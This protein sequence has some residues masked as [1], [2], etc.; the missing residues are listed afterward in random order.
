M[1]N[2]PINLWDAQLIQEFN[3]YL[4][5]IESQEENSPKI[6]VIS[7]DVPDF[8]IA[9]I[10]L[11]LLSVAHPASPTIN[12]TDILDKYYEN[13]NL[14]SRIPVVFIAEINGRAWGAG[15]EHSMHMDI[16]FAG[17]EALFSA[18]EASVGLIHVGAMQW[19]V[20]SL[21]P[22]R[23][24]EYMLGSLQVDATEAVRVGWV[25]SAY[26]TADGLRDHVDQLV[27]RIARFDIN[28]IKATKR[29][30]AQQMPSKAIFDKDQAAF[31][32]LAADPDVQKVVDRVLELSGD[33]G[34]V[35]E[36]NNSDN[37]VEYV[38]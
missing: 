38:L 18:P 26:S 12:T 34:K 9:A 22:S 36:L 13:L 6:V 20:K 4:R 33:Q 3:T 30:I 16:R 35:W 21:G 10:D 15:D 37:I 31:G 2:P 23:T 29:S 24:M 32:T 7:S 17:P 8:Y 1:S 11:H 14:L 27:R 25:N 5:L 19:L 28:A